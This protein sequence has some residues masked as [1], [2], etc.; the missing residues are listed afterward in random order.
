MNYI[1][2]NSDGTET[3]GSIIVTVTAEGTGGNSGSSGGTSTTT[4][5]FNTIYP[6][7]AVGET[8]TITLNNTT[9]SI[10]GVS[11]NSSI[12]NITTQ[13]GTQLTFEGLEK[14]S[15]TVVVTLSNGSTINLTLNVTESTTSDDSPYLYPSSITITIGATATF[16]LYGT[17]KAISN[18]YTVS[19]ATTLSN[20]SST[21]VNVTGLSEGTDYLNVTLTNNKQISATI[22]V[23]SGGSS[24][25]SS[26]GS[27]S[28]EISNAS[29][30]ALTQQYSTSHE[31]IPNIANPPSGGYN[32]KYAPRINPDGSFP[33]SSWN[34][35]GHWMTTYKVEGASYYDNVGLLLQDPVAWIWNS[36][37]KSWDVLSNDFEW[38]NW[39][40][41]D[42]WDDGSGYIAGT[43]QWETGVSGNHS[44]WVK[45]KQTSE[46]SGRCFHPWGY[47]KNWRSN[48]SWANNGCPYIVTKIDF[49]LVKWDE[50]GSDNLDSAQ[51]LVN[52][53]GDWWRNVGDVWQSDWSTNR[54]MCVGKYIKATRELKRAWATNLPNNWG[55]GLPTDGTSS[56]SGSTNSG[57]SSSSGSSSSGSSS[58]G[59]GNTIVDGL[60]TVNYTAT[61]KGV[62]TMWNAL[63]DSITYGA[64][65]SSPSAER[66]QTVASNSAGVSYYYNY[67][68]SGTCVSDGYNTNLTD[69]TTDQ[70]F[71]NRYEEMATGADLI[72]VFGGVN[73]HNLDQKIGSENDTNTK[74]FYGALNTLI[75]GLKSMYPNGRIV[76]ITPFKTSNYNGT[77]QAGAKLVDYRNAIVTACNNKQIEVLDLFTDSNIA[78][79]NYSSGYFTYGDYFHPTSAG[80]QYIGNLIVSKLF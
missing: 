37:T 20:Y 30:T 21:S 79:Q 51:L 77:N 8:L 2:L 69:V 6:V 33:I 14:G 31:A 32:W 58:S 44:T 53:G 54:D 47:Q 68:I 56:S 80:H 48:S 27:S 9:P 19:G 15:A 28:S 40:L 73:D 49:K 12:A 11:F 71:V 52:S 35:F 67:G 50:S 55:Y 24:G 75:N 3:S 63:G 43:T 42:F 22:Y 1:I 23:V 41:E 46:T 65:L 36:S 7:V 62:P 29:E 70:S 64:G 59:T 13:T 57:N 16:N 61:N 10:S 76:F 25:D 4:N 74:T 34:A 66:Y 78:Y 26:G 39:Y 45:I 5:T 17:T 60:V 72:T 38:G 18:A